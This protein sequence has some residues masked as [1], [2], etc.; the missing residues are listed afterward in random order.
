[1]VRNL[2]VRLARGERV[3]ARYRRGSAVS[4]RLA[5][6]AEWVIGRLQFGPVTQTITIMAVIS[7]GEYE[8]ED[9]HIT[10]SLLHLGTLDLRRRSQA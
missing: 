8:H 7:L 1:M 10:A 3:G 9:D 4:I 5:R 2:E 6:V